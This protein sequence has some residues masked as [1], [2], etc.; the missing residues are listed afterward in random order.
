MK[1]NL[2]I[3]ICGIVLV[4]IIVI[5]SL[6]QINININNVNKMNYKFENDKLYFTNNAKD[7]IEVPSDFSYT[8]KHLQETNDGKFR[9]GTYQMD[10][11]KI[12]FYSEV[13]ND[14]SKMINIVDSNGNEIEDL[15]SKRYKYTMYLIYSDDN[16][17][18][19]K[20]A[21]CGTSNYIDSMVSINFTDKDNGK[22]TLN[23]KDND[24]QIN[25]ITKNG[26]LDWDVE[27]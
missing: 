3:L 24:G 13:E 12:I 8:I 18:S 21:W 19:W 16:G 6:I 20:E 9:D 22:M 11:N 5:G 2:K 17:E 25:Y 1:K 26:G 15:N 4:L 10:R 14:F 7:W 27:K 23:N